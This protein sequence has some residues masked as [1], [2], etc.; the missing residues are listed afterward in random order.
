MTSKWIEEAEEKTIWQSSWG[1][2]WIE[3]LPTLERI[4]KLLRKAMLS[5]DDENF[6]EQIRKEIDGE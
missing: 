5:T 1:D 2:G 6:S 3:L 4:D